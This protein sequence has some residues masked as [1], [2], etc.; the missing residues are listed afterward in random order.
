MI[1]QFFGVVMI[2]FGLLFLVQG[3]KNEID[4]KLNAPKDGYFNVI[5]FNNYNPNMKYDN[6][7]MVKKIKLVTFKDIDKPE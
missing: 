2:I 7:D 5:T 3:I 4:L 6:G 1:Y